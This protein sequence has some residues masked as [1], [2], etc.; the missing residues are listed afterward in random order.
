MAD[1][2]GKD[3][4]LVGGAALVLWL[5]LGKT[6]AA[7]A[8]TLGELGV[9]DVFVRTDGSLR[10]NGR[11]SSIDDISRRCSGRVALK[12]SGAASFGDL[13]RVREQLRARGFDVVVAR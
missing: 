9:C 7:T 13:Q 8:G 11:D 12:A 4:A 10:L 1:I 5:L 6:G 2:D 3:I